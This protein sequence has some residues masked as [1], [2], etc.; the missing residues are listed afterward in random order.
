MKKG[1]KKTLI[2]I[3]GR[4]IRL[5]INSLELMKEVIIEFDDFF[6]IINLAKISGW[7]NIKVDELNL[8]TKTNNIKSILPLTF[9]K[10][11]VSE[12][13]KYYNEV[14]NE[15]D[16]DN[17]DNLYDIISW[18]FKSSPIEISMF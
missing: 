8:N 11:E 18:M 16:Y 2:R 7:S 10:K 13:I 9:T 14:A 1:S 4:R 17:I 6:T 15:F 5:P 3:V 12:M